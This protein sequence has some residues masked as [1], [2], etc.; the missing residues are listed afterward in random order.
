MIFFVL[1]FWSNEEDFLRRSLVKGR[2]VARVVRRYWACRQ[3]VNDPFITTEHM[4]C[5]FPL[6]SFQYWI[7]SFHYVIQFSGY[8]RFDFVWFEKPIPSITSRLC[9]CGLSVDMNVYLLST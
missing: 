6:T 8:D 2:L 1:S 9:M 3:G 5:F 7:G 4:V